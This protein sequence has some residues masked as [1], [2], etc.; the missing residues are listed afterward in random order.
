MACLPVQRQNNERR[1]K[2]N[3][4]RKFKD[5]FGL[6]FF[7]KIRKSDFQRKPLFKSGRSEV[8]S[9]MIFS[10]LLPLSEVIFKK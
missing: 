2:S 3:E 10:T 6:V 9:L 7:N 8:Y 4:L 1:K 5:E